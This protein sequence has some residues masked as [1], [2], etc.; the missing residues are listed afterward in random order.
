MNALEHQLDYPLGDT[1]PAGGIRHPVAPGIYWLRMPLPFALDHINLWLLR[2][3]QDGR[4]GWTIVDCGINH[5]TIRAHWETLFADGLDGLPVLRVLVTHCHPDHV[6]LSR[7][8]CE[9]GD[10]RRWNVRLWMSLGDYAF[11][12]M[13]VGGTGA[14]NAGGES[15][16]RHFARHGLTDAEAVERIRNR[17]DYYSTLVPGVPEQYRRIMDGQVIAIGDD[18]AKAGWRV[19]T[20][21]GHAP[22]HVALYSEDA[23]VLISG[24]MVLPRISTNVSVFDIEP[25][26]DPLALYLASLDK[27][28]ALP[29]DVLILPSHGRPFRG[30]HTRIRQLRDHHAD[31]LADTLAACRRAPQ[32]ARDIVDVIFKRQFDVHQM[33]FAM[34]EALAHLHALWHRGELVRETGA[35]GIIRFHVP[36]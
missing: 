1:L 24:D 8:L 19:I 33:T 30:L 3:R 5:E 25:E 14:S 31:R 29:E 32:S 35:D 6:G 4:D 23:N 12:R 2:D 20:G 27:Y 13:L 7:W 18:A 36:A 26:A 21:F 34:G 16:A 9:G 22:E 10:H 11:A 15:A 17:K 28:E